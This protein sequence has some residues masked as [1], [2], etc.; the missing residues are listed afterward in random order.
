[1][2][3]R[4]E[5]IRLFHDRAL[6]FGDFT[7]V[8]GKKSKY[9]LDGKQ[10]TLHAEGLRQVSE[11]LLE[12][13]SDVEFDA[14]GGMSIGAD[15]IIGGVLTVAAEQ[16]KDIVGIMVRKEAKG[17]GTQR[18]IEGPAK[19]GMKVVVIDDVVTTG[20]SSLLA[21][22]RIVEFGCEVVTVVGIVDRMQGGAENF[23]ARDLPFRSLLSIED[24]GIEPPAKGE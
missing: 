6:K 8:S 1:M 22:D 5:L 15:P 18:Y 13:L 11:G 3:N 10:I 14:I 24:F 21:V 2:F 19:E 20:G 23:A 4:E 7:L 9:Y 17:H 16:G 12:L